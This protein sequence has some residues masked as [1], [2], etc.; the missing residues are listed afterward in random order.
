MILAPKV[1]LAYSLPCTFER[2]KVPKTADW[3]KNGEAQQ[4]SAKRKQS[5]ISLPVVI[6][7]SAERFLS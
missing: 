1:L 4:C 3:R 7:L 2:S 6:K 5:S